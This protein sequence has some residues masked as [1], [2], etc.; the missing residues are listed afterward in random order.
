MSRVACGGCTQSIRLMTLIQGPGLG[1]IAHLRHVGLY[2]GLPS[3][4]GKVD[5]K[6]TNTYRYTLDHPRFPSAVY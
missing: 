6:A 4:C 3:C 1:A 2:L 5:G